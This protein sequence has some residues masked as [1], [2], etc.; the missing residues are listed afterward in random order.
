MGF[1]FK[2]QPDEKLIGGGKRV[3]DRRGHCFPFCS[4]AN[5]GYRSQTNQIYFGLSAVMFH[6]H[7]ALIFDNSVSGHMDLGHR[8]FVIVFQRSP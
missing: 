4:K 8:M 6:R 7:Y 5:E 3:L 2:L 1:R